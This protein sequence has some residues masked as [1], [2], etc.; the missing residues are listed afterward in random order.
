MMYDTILTERDA[1]AQQALDRT[2]LDGATKRIYIQTVDAA[3]E[4]ALQSDPTVGIEHSRFYIADNA[5][6]RM[7]RW[8]IVQ[9]VEALLAPARAE[10]RRLQ[11]VIR[12]LEADAE[13]RRIR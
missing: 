2:D 3:Y 6:R 10:I 8:L 4:A 11:A 12:V 1:R 13:G 9:S 5:L 7:R